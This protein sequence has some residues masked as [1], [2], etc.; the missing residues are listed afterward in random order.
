[1]GVK[2]ALEGE[3]NGYAN[4]GN[5]ATNQKFPRKKSISQFR[6]VVAACEMIFSLKQ[7]KLMPN[8]LMRHQRR[9]SYEITTPNLLFNTW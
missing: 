3:K 8:T 4:V 6:R 1:M 5:H 7:R 2:P 9:S